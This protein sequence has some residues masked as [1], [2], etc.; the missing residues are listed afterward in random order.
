M[1]Y[2]S[3]DT[4]QLRICITAAR[5]VLCPGGWGALRDLEGR[6]TDREQ[7]PGLQIRGAFGGT[8][9]PSLLIRRYL[10]GVQRRPDPFAS[11]GDRQ[12]PVRIRS[13]GVGSRSRGWLRR[14]LP[15]TASSSDCRSDQRHLPQ[16]SVGMPVAALRITA[17]RAG[18][19]YMRPADGVHQAQV[20]QFMSQAF[21]RSWPAWRLGQC[22]HSYLGGKPATSP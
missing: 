9:P 17:D 1:R 19:V 7:S 8:R 20:P 10:S 18:L 11:W 6:T 2:R 22:G 15:V 13:P 21:K 5:R 4:E 16:G 14:W 12:S 3:A